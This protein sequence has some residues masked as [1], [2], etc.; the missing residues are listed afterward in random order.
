MILCILKTD[1]KGM[2]TACETYNLS[3]IKRARNNL[4]KKEIGF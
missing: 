1:E 3:A 2:P 4:N